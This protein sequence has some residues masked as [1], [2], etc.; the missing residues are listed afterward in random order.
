[1][2]RPS[3]QMSLGTAGIERGS[4]EDPVWARTSKG[5]GGMA[6]LCE[7]GLRASTGLEFSTGD[8]LGL[9]LG[10]V[11]DLNKV[12]TGTI[13]GIS[14]GPELVRVVALD[15]IAKLQRQRTNKL[16]ENQSCGQMTRDLAGAAGVGIGDVKEGIQLPFYA[17]DSSRS[18]HEH[19]RNLA[20]LCGFETYADAEDFLVFA[21]Y[22]AGAPVPLEYGGTVMAAARLGREPIYGSVRVFGESPSSSKGADSVHWLSKEPVDSSSGEGNL[23]T[24]SNAAVRDTETARAVSEAVLTAVSGGPRLELKVIGNATVSLNGTVQVA[25][26][27]DEGLNGEYQVRGVEHS[28][29]KRGGFT[30]TLELA[31]GQVNE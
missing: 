2:L 26:M 27:P 3:F 29:S 13:D 12:F 1:M 23:L 10:Y 15:S 19:M 9:S 8:P 22:E 11:G 31:G 28:F 21:P 20:L 16:F 14:R 7:I 4:P 17:V 6:G 30:S 25:G 24:V 5:L 18:V